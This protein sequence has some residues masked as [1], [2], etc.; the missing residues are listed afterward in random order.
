M[1]WNLYEPTDP[2]VMK[3]SLHTI[4]CHLSIRYV[5]EAQPIPAFTGGG[6]PRYV[7]RKQH[8]LTRRIRR[9]LTEMNIRLQ[10]PVSDIEGVVAMTVLRAIASATADARK[11]VKL[12]HTARFKAVREEP[13]VSPEGNYRLPSVTM[14]RMKPEEYDFFVARMKKYESCMGAD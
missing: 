3:K 1:I 11:P 6:R 8:H 9:L 2:T 12:V 7:R 5:S 10:H 13:E 14:L 4:L